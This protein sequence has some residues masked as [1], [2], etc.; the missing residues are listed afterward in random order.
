[1]LHVYGIYLVGKGSWKKTEVERFEVGKFEVGK[2]PIK[3]GKFSMQNQKFSNFG[4]NFPTK[5]FPI[6]F[7]TLELLV[8]SNCLFQLNVSHVHLIRL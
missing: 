2:F 3:V 6:S 5:F 8:F 7:R 4:S 1:L